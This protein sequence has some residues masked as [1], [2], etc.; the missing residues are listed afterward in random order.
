M[1]DSDIIEDL[2]A[3]VR[4]EFPQC[5]DQQADRMDERIRS[6]W[7]GQRTHIAK[8][9]HRKPGRAAKPPEVLQRAYADALG[10]APTSEVTRRNGVSRATLYRLL[11][12]GPPEQS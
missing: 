11:K 8:N 5:T 3:M 7:G 12:K 6:L 1:S 4:A 10:P 2:L 9:K